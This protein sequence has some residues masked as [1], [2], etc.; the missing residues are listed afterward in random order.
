MATIGTWSA[1]PLR[2]DEQP[3]LELAAG[4]EDSLVLKSKR[5]VLQ[6]VTGVQHPFMYYDE[7]GSDNTKNHSISFSSFRSWLL[8][9]CIRH[10]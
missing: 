3:S 7:T 9:L 2:P 8:R 4:Q 10:A 6:V 1:R 5:E